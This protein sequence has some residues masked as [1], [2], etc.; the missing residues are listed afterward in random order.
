MLWRSRKAPAPVPEEAAPAP[1]PSSPSPPP[2]SPRPLSPS[3]ASP[4][5]GLI[6]FWT[7]AL[8]LLV[9]GAVLLQWLG[10]LHHPAPP[11]SADATSSGSG[12]ILA[13]P[14]ALGGTS[15]PAGGIAAPSP[16]LLDLQAGGRA[17]PR[18]GANGLM[19]A[20]AYAAWYDRADNHPRVA[21]LLASIGLSEVDSDNAIRTLPAAVSLAISP[22]APRLDRLL[23]DAR[24]SGHETLIA[25]PMEPNGYP[26]N[27]AGER[28]LLTGLDWV[29]NQERLE[30]VLG[31]VLGYVGAT[32]ALGGAMGGLRG[33]R[34]ADSPQMDLVLAELGRRGL[35]WLDARP[36]TTR[37]AGPAQL[38]PGQ[39][40]VDLVI[41]ESPSRADIDDRLAELA[42]I[43]RRTGSAVG[44][45]GAPDPVTVDR[46]A[47]WA[48]SLPAAG[49]SLVP[50]SALIPLPRPPAASSAQPGTSASPELPTR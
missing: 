34:F 42:D 39:R 29:Q 36:P 15:A 9:A 35:L 12:P 41:D 13:S 8:V 23:A 27:D 26:R 25:L 47:T 32:S 4:W 37:P 7:L 18:I 45:V 1:S 49:V 30:G 43:A 14:F 21:L 17:L 11:P 40:R 16:A 38:R 28:A 48:T 3:R 6:A 50:V 10:P 31:R 33:E 2:P 46:L 20:H 5:R 44:V 19:P 24:A 22:Y